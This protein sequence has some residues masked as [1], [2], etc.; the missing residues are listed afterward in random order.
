MGFVINSGQAGPAGPAGETGPAG[1][2]GPAGPLASSET[3]PWAELTLEPEGA[4]GALQWRTQLAGQILQLV[5][6]VTF[7]AAESAV[8]LVATLPNT[9]TVPQLLAV[10]VA[11]YT[12]QEA[13]VPDAATLVISTDGSITLVPNESAT[14]PAFWVAHSFP[15]A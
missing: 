9:V 13:T 6:S 2:A 10:P 12:T 11:C 8:T 15:L 7:A 3:T 14:V 5:G 1:P 4:T